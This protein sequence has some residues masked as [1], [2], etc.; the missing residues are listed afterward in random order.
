MFTYF[1]T[2]ITYTLYIP[3]GFS[4]YSYIVCRK[5]N[6]VTRWIGHIFGSLEFSVHMTFG[7]VQT[8]SR[9]QNVRFEKHIITVLK[10]NNNK[11]TYWIIIIWNFVFIVII[12][13]FFRQRNLR[14]KMRRL[15]KISMETSPKKRNSNRRTTNHAITVRIRYYKTTM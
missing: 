13:L 14:V 7:K 3:I 1:E 6:R 8:L 4:F 10:L 9:R 12:Y 11:Y 15:L 5:Q 2:N